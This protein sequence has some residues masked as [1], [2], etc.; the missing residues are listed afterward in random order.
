MLMIMIQTMEHGGGPS[1]EELER[2]LAGVA[3]GEREAFASLY[4][5]TR[6]A[7]YALALSILKNT[8]DA[9]DVTQDAFVRLWDSAPQ[10]RPQGTPMAWILTITRNLARMRLRQSARTAELDD[11]AWEAIPA[12]APGV[13]PEDKHLLQA[14]LATLTDQER[15][16]VL[17]HAVTGLKHREIA[18]LLEIPVA[19][20]LSKYHRALRKLKDFV[21]GD[22]AL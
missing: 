2:L 8:H 5:R 22:D 20:A 1:R 9:Q 13:T 4:H 7:V 18:A 10:Y 11:Q 6:A 12:D 14:A 17:L 19:T 21:K 15:Q 3:A 16:V